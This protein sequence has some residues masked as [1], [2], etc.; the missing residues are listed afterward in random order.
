EAYTALSRDQ[1]E[2]PDYIG[3]HLPSRRGEIYFKLGYYNVAEIISMKA[4]SGGFTNNQVEHG[5]PNSLG[6]ILLFDAR[7]CALI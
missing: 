1:V 4:H 7:S 2:H 5:V 6:T 3:I